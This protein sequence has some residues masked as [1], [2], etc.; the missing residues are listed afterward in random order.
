MGA[1]VFSS[2]MHAGGIILFSEYF[3]LFM[4]QGSILDKLIAT[5]KVIYSTEKYWYFSY[6]SMGMCVVVLIRSAL[7]RGF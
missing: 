5:D 1:T 7:L 6:F 3:C 4:G 2:N